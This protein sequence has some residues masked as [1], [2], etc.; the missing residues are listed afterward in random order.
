MAAK[1]KI[2][3]AT[4]LMEQWRMALPFERNPHV[5]DKVK[6]MGVKLV[7]G[8]EGNLAECVEHGNSCVMHEVMTPPPEDDTDAS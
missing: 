5:F 4:M 6:H 2:Y 3:P 1:L 7:I 8:C